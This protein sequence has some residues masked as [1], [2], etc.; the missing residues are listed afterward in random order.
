M[1]EV[2]NA[3]FETLLMLANVYYMQKSV[4]TVCA[5]ANDIE[6][7]NSCSIQNARMTQLHTESSEWFM[8]SCS[9]FCNGVICAH[10]G[11]LVCLHAGGA[12]ATPPPG[13]TARLV[14]LLNFEWRHPH[15][16]AASAAAVV[17]A[18]A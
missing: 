2:Y 13:V 4:Y 15:S 9:F 18:A 12:G 1:S 17:V 10:F 8:T 7:T 6:R 5:R 3:N 11:S 16:G 14:I